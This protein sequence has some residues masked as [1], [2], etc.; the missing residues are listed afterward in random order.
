MI[1]ILPSLPEESEILSDI[2]LESKGHW[3]YSREQLEIW[4]KDLKIEEKYIQEHSV[5]TIWKDSKIVGF[6]AIIEGKENLLDHL[7]LHPEVIGTGLGSLAFR[8]IIKEMERLEI[9]DFYIISDPDAEGFYLHQGAKKVGEVESIP[10]NRMLPKLQYKIKE[11][12]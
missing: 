7:W 1:E 4:R 2:A 5:R 8:E 11:K 10:Q 12:P 9:E 3:G 6:F